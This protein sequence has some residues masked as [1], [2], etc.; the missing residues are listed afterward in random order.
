MTDQTQAVEQIARGLT[1]AQRRSVLA[2]R[3]SYGSGYWP[4]YNAMRDKGLITNMMGNTLTPLGLAVR[5][6]IQEQGS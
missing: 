1:K 2:G 5:N 6:H 3:V 4:L